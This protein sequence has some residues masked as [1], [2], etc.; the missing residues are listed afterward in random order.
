MKATFD[1]TKLWQSKAKHTIHKDKQINT[2]H[3]KAQ[4]ATDSWGMSSE[5]ALRVP[6][7]GHK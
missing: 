3:S 1:I 2:T 7:S 6:Y 4:V 5:D